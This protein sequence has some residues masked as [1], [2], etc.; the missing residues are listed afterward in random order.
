MAKF[1]STLLVHEKN[2]TGTAIHLRNKQFW[3]T[4]FL[5]GLV[6]DTEVVMNQTRRFSVLLQELVGETEELR[7]KLKF[8]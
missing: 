3:N 1:K 2:V 6:L 7:D 8:Q 5:H 4:G